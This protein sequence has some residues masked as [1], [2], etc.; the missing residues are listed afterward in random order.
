MTSLS[1]NSIPDKMTATE[2]PPVYRYHLLRAALGAGHSGLAELDDKCLTD[3]ESQAD[4][5]FDLESL[6]LG[7]PEAA[8]AVI[9]PGR[10]EEALS[11]LRGR[12]PDRNAFIAD[13][14][15]NGL[16]EE[17]LGRALERELIFDAVMQA[18]SSRRPDVTAIDE[19]LF[20]ELHK[21]RFCRPERRT[22]RH[23]LITVNDQFEENRRDASLSRI[24]RL[25]EKLDGRQNR[26][27]SLAREHSECP[28]AMEEGRLGTLP[29]GRLYPELDA[30]LFSLPEGGISG[31]VESDMG[32]HLLWCEKIHRGVAP[33]FSKARPR[34]RQLLEERAARN[35]QKA[36][37]SALQRSRS[38]ESSCAQG[39][40][41]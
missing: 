17:T 1:L 12:Y 38:S 4:K 21:E 40:T 26:F 19:R 14:T 29:R 33:P 25:A 27:P 32:F 15:E 22:A 28:S 5:S 6:V 10:I 35:C 2:R 9:P 41:S 34:I 8:R 24:E 23:I 30:V 11:E 31:P 39:R 36:W 37:I 18:V 16:D 3:I 13:L 20:F 7:S